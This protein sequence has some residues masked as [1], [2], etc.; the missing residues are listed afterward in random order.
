[1]S[2]PTRTVG[3]ARNPSPAPVVRLLAG[4]NHVALVT[5]DLARLVE[6]Y[7]GVFDAEVVALEDDAPFRHA[8]L[9][10]G[11]GAGL[12]AFEIADSAHA[13]GSAEMFGRGH[14]DHL[15]LNAPTEEAFLELRRRLVERGASDGSITDF[16][17]VLSVWF[18]DPDGMGSEVVWVRDPEL[19]G[20]HG[21][22]AFA[23]AGG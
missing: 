7:A 17:P 5:A 20:G 4:V 13:A 1:M 19:R 16:G 15:G 10:V 3:G 6:F 21:P 22:E 11:A 14:L 8:M 9:L 18:E 2:A 12:H 23:E